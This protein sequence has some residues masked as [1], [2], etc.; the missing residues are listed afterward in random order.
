[1]TRIFSSASADRAAKD[2]FKQLFSGEPFSSAEM[3]DY[4][5]YEKRFESTLQRTAAAI[6]LVRDPNNRKFM[7]S[8]MAGKVQMGDMFETG[9]LGIHFTMFLTFIKT[10]ASEEQQKMWL[11]RAQEGRFF[12]AYAQTELGHGSNVRGLETV[13]TFDRE[14]DEFVI[15]SPTLTSLKWWPTGMYACTHGVVMAQLVIDGKSYGF[16]GF[17]VQFRDDHGNLMPGVEVGEMGPK[18]NPDNTNIGY[19]RFSHVR[20]PRFNMFAKFQQVTRDGKYVAPPPKLEKFRYISMMQIR[21][22]LVGSSFR[23]LSHAATIA[24]RYSCVRKQGFKDTSSSPGVVTAAVAE[25]AVIDYRVQQYRTFRA[26]ATAYCFYFNAMYM[27]RYLSRIQSAVSNGT[28][29]ERDSAAAEMPELHATLSGLK[30]WSTLYAHESIEDCRKACGGQGYL[31]SSGVCALTTDFTEPATVEGEQVI[32][33]LQTARFLI[34]AAAEA[35]AGRPVVGSV[36]YLN[37]APMTAVEARNWQGQT[38]LLLDL[39]RDRAAR[40]ARKL[41]ASF[42]KERSQGKSFDIALNAV[43]ILAYKAAECHS[44]YAMVSNNHRALMELVEPGNERKAAERLLDLLMLIRLREQA[45]DW[46]GVLTEPALDSAND[47][48]NELL[49]EIRP[50]CVGLVDAFGWSDSELKSTLGRYDGNVYEA[51][52]A[53]AKKSPLNE[54][55]KMLGWEHLRP[56]LDIEFLTEGMKHQRADSRR[57]KL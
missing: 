38:Q 43:A 49:G 22:M 8:H 7:M 32:L 34:K 3:R 6:A 44:L 9:G 42:N 18:I 17:M 57:A 29:Q 47:R 10:N 2:S 16:H 50:D 27:N 24:V 12:G 35:E 1:M 55:P 53:E 45:G 31:R 20:V 15:H 4:M 36:E 30:V 39:F 46:L 25:N 48:I 5:S 19:A 14:T 41:S 33:S 37:V 56:I 40:F 13:A 21:M 52:Y 51:I 26:L 11:E 28:D 23:A 54:R